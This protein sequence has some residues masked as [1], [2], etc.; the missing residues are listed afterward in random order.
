MNPQRVKSFIVML[1]LASMLCGPRPAIACGPFAREAIF[2]Y[3]KHPDLPLDRFA[4]GELGVL[5]P[6]YARSYLYVAYRYMNSLSFTTAEQQALMS[7]WQDR[8]SFDWESSAEDG[9]NAWL[10]ARKKVNV[11]DPV[12]EVEIYR[13]KG[14]E[15]YD[16]FLNC[17]SA[18]F[19]N[20]AQTL[21]ARVKQFGAASP[22]VKDWVQA[23]DKVFANCGGGESIP[24]AASSSAEIIRADRAYQI[25]A[26]KFY[27]M[28]FDDAQAEFEKVSGDKSSPYHQTARYMVARTLIRKASLGEEANRNATLTQ[29]ET[30]LNRTLSEIKQ[31]PLHDSSARLLNLVK[32]RLRP[33]ERLRELS[34]S[35]MKREPNR[36]LKQE[37]W[38]YTVILDSYLGSEDEPVDE[39]V[40]K[41]QGEIIDLL[42]DDMSDWIRTFQASGQ[43][44][45][46]HALE[47]WKETDSRAWLVAALSKAEGASEAHSPLIAAADRI[48]PA[49]PAYAAASFHAVRLLI[50]KGDRAGARTRLDAILK[51]NQSSLPPSA[52]NQFL[53]QRMLL[54][55]NLEE[56]LRYAQRLPAAF[57]WGEDGRELP[58][59]TKEL[60]E[61]RELKQLAGLTLFDTDATGIM[62]EQFPLS[63]LIEAA[64]SPTLPAHLRKRIALDGWT[65]AVLL[66]DSEAG[67]TLAPMLAGLAP[68]MRA[69]LNEYVAAGTDSDRRGVALYTLLKFPGTRPFVAYGVGRFT[70]LNERDIYR[71]NW[72]CERSFD[73]AMEN[74]QEQTADATTSASN[75]AK[76]VE[77]S[78][79]DFLTAEQKVAGR[80][81]RA[82]L[83]LLGA[84][85]NYL[86]REVV[87]WANRAPNNA[88]IP[89]ALHLAVVAT[90]Y[91]CVNKETGGFSRAAWQLL[92]S[93]YKNSEW[94]KRTPYWF[95][96]Y[97]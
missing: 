62:N 2:S 12:P 16:N 36:D 61:D 63:V 25:A 74:E 77:A 90:R 64:R 26:A 54:S 59:S 22:E 33:A 97:E 91:G 44:S 3:R 42:K 45:F 48:E 18:A 55:A 88:R 39:N 9:K 41:S 68:E 1:V 14:K 27:S 11:T 13:A 49:S 29:A 86:A 89:E 83:R 21:E 34:Q 23:Q 81:E 53:H 85:P 15:Q 76:G 5:Q 37:L 72:W 57:S 43:D 52:I 7:L 47:K 87:N 19:E 82:E 94:A 35:L 50:E 80:R 20:A 96:G 70:P 67:K 56:F 69:L 58:I 84:A 31:G 79:P 17:P 93:R 30:E 4:R 95:K 73:S 6:S 51:Q 92:H 8:L 24:D 32:L 46:R 40:K 60:N 38:D 65:R 75:V 78:L 28:R 71:D 66:N 10:A